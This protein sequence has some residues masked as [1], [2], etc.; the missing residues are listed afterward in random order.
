MDDFLEFEKDTKTIKSINLDD[1][2][3]EDLNE[4]IEQLKKEIDR[5]KSELEKK[6]KSQTEAEKYFK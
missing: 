4:Y 1:F 5:V 3:V 2:S 6:L